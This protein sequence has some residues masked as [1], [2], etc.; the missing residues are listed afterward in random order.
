MSVHY[1]CTIGS[2]VSKNIAAK[3]IMHRFEA[4]H[5]S[6][7]IIS[8]KPSVLLEK[9]FRLVNNE[10]DMSWPPLISAVSTNQERVDI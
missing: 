5:D 10:S 8:N 1:F 6:S 2:I 3:F 4:C 7:Q 9:G